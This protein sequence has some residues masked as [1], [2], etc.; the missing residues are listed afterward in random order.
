MHHV[1]AA[2]V[3]QAFALAVAHR[4]EAAGEAFNVVAPSAL[5]V[6]GLLAIAADW[7][8][9]PLHTRSVS[10]EEFRSTTTPEFAATSWEHLSRSQYASIDKART[11]LGYVP[12]YEPEAAILDGVR[13]LIAHDQLEVAHP[14]RI[15]A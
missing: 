2:D 4:D 12:A 9:Q 15:G 3:A 14:L 8:G 13:W 11:L 6:R 1:H 5:T 7:F 10:W